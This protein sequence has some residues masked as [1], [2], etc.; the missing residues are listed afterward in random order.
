MLKVMVLMSNAEKKNVN[1]QTKKTLEARLVWDMWCNEMLS[2]K[3]DRWTER[4]AGRQAGRKER[5]K[6]NKNPFQSYIH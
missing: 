2:R 1:K 3:T 5:K 6:K 4:Q